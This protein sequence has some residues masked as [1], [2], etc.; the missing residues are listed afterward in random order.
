M[1]ALLLFVL[2]LL[3]PTMA[4]AQS[5]DD[6]PTVYVASVYDR[7]A[8]GETFEPPDAFYTP[9]LLALWKDMEKDAGG[10]V[11]RIDFSYW[12]SSQDWDLADLSIASQFVDGRED[13]QIVTARFRNAGRQRTIV[14]YFEKLD[15]RWRLD[16]AQSPGEDAWTLSTIL[17]YGWTDAP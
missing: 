6:A 5:L 17:K 14:L 1:R 15:G 4:R 3:A 2:L 9:R 8:R 12:T 13:R 7:L 10:E 16:E 11:G